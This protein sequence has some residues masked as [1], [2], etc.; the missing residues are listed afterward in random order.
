MTR[1][2]RIQPVALVDSRP[3]GFSQVVRAC[4]EFIFVSGQVALDASGRLV[5]RG[6]LVAQTHQ[7][8]KNVDA[9]LKAASA[10]FDDVV[11]LTIYIVDYKPECR[12]Q[13][14]EVRRQYIAGNALPAS[15]LI[16]VQ[17][18]A[19]PDFLIEIEAI[20]LVRED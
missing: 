6:D 17:A 9:A 3:A 12:A 20:A 18:L 1:I 15:T 5:G 10:S 8:M 11:K 13:I 19:A 4:G 7:A 16:G 14:L 2:R